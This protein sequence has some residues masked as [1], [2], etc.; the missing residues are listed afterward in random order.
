MRKFILIA[1]LMLVPIVFSGDQFTINVESAYTNPYP[2]EPGQTFVLGIQV[3]NVGTDKVNTANIILDPTRPFT[4]LEDPKKS[5]SNLGSDDRKIIEYKV[6]VDSS[7]I[8]TVYDIPV[9]I[10]Y[11]SLATMTK[12]VQVRVMGTPQFEMLGV[13]TDEINPG[14]R[15]SLKIEFQNVG[16]G[17]AKKMTATFTSTSD[18]ITPIF[19]G[20]NVFINEFKPGEKQWINFNILIDNDA[21]YGVYPGTITLKYT[22]ES[23]NNHTSTYS[24]GILVSGRPKFD[25]VK[26]EI[27]LKNKNLEVEV[28]NSGTA[29][30]V[31]IKADLW[32][33][34]KLYDTYYT[35]QIKIDKKGILKFN[36]PPSKV[37]TG[38]L[39]IKYKGLDNQEFIQEENIVWKPV[40]GNNTILI[41]VGGLVIVYLVL[42][43]PW[44]RIKLYRKGK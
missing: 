5:I 35:T 39:I 29:S 13:L 22:D 3:I 28:V 2:V 26:S 34:D 21:D 44:K 20:G 32:I 7:A 40:S 30:A 9:K 12:N 19:S 15:E 14:E 38:K 36:V 11:G 37:N 18:L 23:G 41:I 17:T 6:F 16:T 25:V 43:K 27:N 24:I 8:S 4:V 42:K 31:A 10:V 1:L 33:E